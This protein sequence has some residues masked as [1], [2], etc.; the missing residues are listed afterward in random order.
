MTSNEK[1]T[2]LEKIDLASAE[3]HAPVEVTFAVYVQLPDGRMGSMRAAMPPGQI[4]SRAAMRLVLDSFTDADSKIPGAP[5]G[6][7]LATRGEFVSHLVKRET[8]ETFALDAGAQ[9]SPIPSDVPHSM[10]VHAIMGCE[11]AD[12]KLADEYDSRGILRIIEDDGEFDWQWDEEKLSA[13]PDDMLLSI[14]QRV[15]A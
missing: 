2:G 13:L 15:T 7:R 5:V 11:V 4:P 9:Y 3:V 12:D 6:A 14:Y 8:G 10:L 1:F